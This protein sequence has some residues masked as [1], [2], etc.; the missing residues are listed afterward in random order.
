MNKRSPLLS[1][2]VIMVLATDAALPFCPVVSPM[3]NLLFK[4]CFCLSENLDFLLGDLSAH[5]MGSA[6][7][8]I[9]VVLPLGGCK[10]CTLV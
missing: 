5:P 3:L 7:E 9:M 10:A 6:G 1:L 4:Y 8:F 2:A